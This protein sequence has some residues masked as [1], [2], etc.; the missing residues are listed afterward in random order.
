MKNRSR[1]WTK[2]DIVSVF[3]L[4]WKLTHR[5]LKKYNVFIGWQIKLDTK[6]RLRPAWIQTSLRIRSVWSGS[7]L[8]A[9]SFSTC[10]RVCKWTA[11]GFWS[12]CAEALAG[13][14]PCW[15]QWHYVGFVITWLIKWKI[16]AMNLLLKY[17]NECVV[18]G[19]SEMGFSVT[20]RSFYAAI[21]NSLVFEENILKVESLV[22]EI[23]PMFNLERYNN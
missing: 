16:E 13:L 2:F 18:S 11:Y 1:L 12:G 14:D 9:T 20:A 3:V 4:L 10:Y 15:S 8:F 6:L 22:I 19:S 7:M 5:I 21:M 23:R 17:L